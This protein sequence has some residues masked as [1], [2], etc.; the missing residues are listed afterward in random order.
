M[1]VKVEKI[2]RNAV[3]CLKCGDI[4]ESKHRHD[5]VFCSCERIFVDGGKDYF[6]RG[7]DSVENFTDLSETIEVIEEITSED[8]KKYYR[9]MHPEQII[10]D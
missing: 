2:V 5:F 6:R 8:L 1:K 9:D 10:E 3:K 7:F 4:I